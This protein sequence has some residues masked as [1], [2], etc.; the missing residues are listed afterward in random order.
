MIEHSRLRVYRLT[1]RRTTLL[2]CRDK[3]NDWR[4][5]LERREA[6][7]LLTA[8]VLQVPGLRGKVRVFDPWFGEW[9]NP[10][11]QK[12]RIAL[13]EFKRSMVLRAG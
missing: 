5:E 8:Q 10:R 3:R 12:G 11:P 2:W 9:T 4:T 6:P 13:P 1:G 7:E